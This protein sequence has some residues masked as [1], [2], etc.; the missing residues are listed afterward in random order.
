MSRSD[1]MTWDATGLAHGSEQ[2][3]SQQAALVAA[4]EC[5]EMRGLMTPASRVSTH[6]SHV[7]LSNTRAFK[8][9]RAVCLSFVDFSGIEQR[10][11]A[12]EAELVHN[13]PMAGSLYEA[14]LPLTRGSDRRYGIDDAGE[15]VDWVVVMRRFDE[16]Q[17]FDRM[18]E[19]GALCPALV[20]RLAERIAR[21]HAARPPSPNAGR[22]SE[23]R[24]LL[25]NLGHAEATL[26]NTGGAQPPASL[27][28]RL[29]SRL[30]EVGHKIER[31]RKQG[32]VRRGHGDLHLRN[33]CMFNGA[34][35]PFDALEFDERL[36]TTD[37]LYDLAFLLM[38]LRR[39]GLDACAAAAARRYWE[40][41]GEEADAAELLPFFMATRAAVRMA[42]AAETGDMAG[43]GAYRA[44][45]TELLK[46]SSATGR[47]G[48]TAPLAELGA[49]A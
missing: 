11:A 12:C 10:R 43:A 13:R 18:A 7:F 9:K 41:A 5:G 17:Q 25:G 2:E 21:F 3:H 24:T 14:A 32:R 19:R 37:V 47:T 26:M 49:S 38:D 33:I 39:V 6:L 1:A 36:A 48:S 31:R 20:E 15:I 8:L 22:V 30:S 44:H 27:T 34:P 42:I 35:T 16:T 28:Q 4:F 29:Q 40:A 23:Y 46:R 45:G